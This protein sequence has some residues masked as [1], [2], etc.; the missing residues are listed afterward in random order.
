MKQKRQQQMQKDCTKQFANLALQDPSKQVSC[1]MTFS[2]RF[3]IK[4]ISKLK[5]NGFENILKLKRIFD[6]E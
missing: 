4:N 6:L 2:E 1:S 5:K 3:Q